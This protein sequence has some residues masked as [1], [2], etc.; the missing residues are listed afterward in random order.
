M[1]EMAQSLQSDP[2]FAALQEQMQEQMRQLMGGGGGMPGMMPGMMGGGGGMQ[3][4]EE[5]MRMM[6]QMM[7]NPDFK[8]MT[9]KMS[10]H[11]MRDPRMS[12]LMQGMQ[13]PSFKKK[14]EE[15]YEEMKKRNG[16]LEQ[17]VRR[18]KAALKQQRRPHSSRP[19]P[20]KGSSCSSR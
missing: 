15:H 2:Q 4:P 16:H 6:Q 8:R 11:L 7:Q 5:A 14:M 20:R 17:D 19:T 18:L 10:E 13:D 9:E 12:S 3:N 1:Q